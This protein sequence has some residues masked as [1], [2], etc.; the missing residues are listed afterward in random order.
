MRVLVLLL[1]INAFSNP[2]NN[3]YLVIHQKQFTVEGNT[4]VGRF[5]CH[6]LFSSRD[7]LF[8][9][10]QRQTRTSSVSIPVRAFSCGNFFLN[11]DFRKTLRAKEFPNITIDFLRIKPHKNGL[12]CDVRIHL[13]G[14]TKTYRQ[15]RLWSEQGDLIGEMS[16]QFSEFN[17]TPPKKA[18][19]I[20]RVKEEIRLRLR[21]TTENI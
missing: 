12:I 5:E 15:V 4:S 7:T 14:K 18:G 3:D 13:A 21:L 2:L 1:A 10:H 9:N 6:Y 16:I 20:V 11:H 19:G 8:F 17:L